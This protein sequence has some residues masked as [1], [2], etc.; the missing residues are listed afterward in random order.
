MKG[1]LI[2]IVSLVLLVALLLATRAAR[3]ARSDQ[4]QN[5]YSGVAS[6]TAVTTKN[7]PFTRIISETGVLTGN[8]ESMIAA[9]TGG[10]VTA[11]LV[12]VGDYVKAGEA[13]LKID[14]ELYGLEAERAK[15]TYEKAKADL[16]RI[17]KL[18][19]QNGAS[20]SDLEG[21]RLAA[22]GAEV[23][24]KM[25][26]K[27][28]RDGTVK[29]PFSGVIAAKYTE[30]GQM[31]GPGTPVVQLIDHS[32]VKL[33]VQV[34]EESI[35]FIPVGAPTTVTI[36]ALN[37][38]FDARVASIGLKASGGART[39]PVEVRF[40]GEPKVRS[41]MFARAEIEAGVINSIVLPRVAI[42]PDAGRS[43]VFLAKNNLA[44]KAIVKVLGQR[45]DNIAVEG[46]PEG[47]IVVTTG[48]QLLTN[49]ASLTI[50]MAKDAAQ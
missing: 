25:A 2:I 34:P 30:V 7:E 19:K 6:V 10:Q 17:E 40:H 36:D 45:G 26:D 4:L 50:T 31:I 35:G 16:E 38:S 43:I 15:I 3:Q 23:G 49:G 42:L 11:L 8:K 46:L 1:K 44:E 13:I 21:M 24:Y 47:A 27:T 9:Q 29:A 39:F 20:D 22:K 28:Y 48:N 32:T 5:P 12:D 14:D 33:V 18:H 41:G 37:A